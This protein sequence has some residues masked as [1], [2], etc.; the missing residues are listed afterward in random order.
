LDLEAANGFDG[1][2]QLI[3]PSGKTVI[4]QNQ[5]ITQGQQFISFDISNLSAG[6]YYLRIS[7]GSGQKVVPIIKQ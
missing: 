4:N 7:N 6:L 5:E 3:T 1:I 2:F